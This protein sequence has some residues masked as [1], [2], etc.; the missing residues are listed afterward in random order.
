MAVDYSTAITDRQD[1]DLLRFRELDAKRFSDMTAEE[2]AEWLAGS[3]ATYNIS[4]LNRVSGFIADLAEQ[5]HNM[6]T[7]VEVSPK[8]DWTRDDIPTA[9]QLTQYI[10]DIKTLKNALA[11]NAPEIPETVYN[12]TLEGANAI[13]QLCVNLNQALANLAKTGFY[14]DELYSGEAYI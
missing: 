6:G 4:D 1:A 12:L 3:K 7:T 2:Q 11:F 9:E 8:T 13:E 5:L 10:S 14:C